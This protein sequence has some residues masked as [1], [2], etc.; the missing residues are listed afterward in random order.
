MGKGSDSMPGSGDSEGGSTPNSLQLHAHAYVEMTPKAA[1]S[2]GKFV[3]LRQ[4]NQALYVVFSPMSRTP[5]HADIV[6]SFLEEFRLAEVNRRDSGHVQVITPGWSV[7]GGGYYRLSKEAPIQITLFGS[8]QAYGKFDL[9][10]L[11]P[12]CAKLAET[13]LGPGGAVLLA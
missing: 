10:L 2:E 9:E 12:Y 1:G 7:R 3:L 5:Y 4:R 13:L 8:S 11:K 6:E